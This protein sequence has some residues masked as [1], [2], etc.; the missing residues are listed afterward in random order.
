MVRNGNDAEANAIA[1]ATGLAGAIG[2][3]CLLLLFPGLFL[4]GAFAILAVPL[5][6]Q[7]EVTGPLGEHDALLAGLLRVGGQ[8]VSRRIV[9]RHW[10]TI[11]IGGVGVASPRVG[12]DVP[13]LDRPEGV[14]I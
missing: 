7:L 5:G 6:D 3:L 4:S 8:V 11:G 1:Y 14:L 10:R 2:R 9:R 12:V 13:V